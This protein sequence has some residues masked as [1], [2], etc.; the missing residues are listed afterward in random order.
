MN[1][2]IIASSLLLAFGLSITPALGDLEANPASNGIQYAAAR[3]GP[4]SDQRVEGS[5]W[6][7]CQS[8]EGAVLPLGENVKVRLAPKTVAHVQ[9]SEDGYRIESLDG[10]AFVRID[11]P[12]S[13]SVD[14]STGG[15]VATQGEFVVDTT[16]ESAP[17]EVYSG[18]ARPVINEESSI[19]VAGPDVRERDEESDEARR[20]RL[21]GSQHQTPP[22]PVPP[23]VPPVPPAV[24]PAPVPPPV[25]PPNVST[26]PPPAQPTTVSQAGGFNPAWVVVPLAV[27]GGI[28]AL[29][30]GGGGDNPNPVASP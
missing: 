24:P 12:T 6:V 25:P 26:P 13:V 30:S 10:V 5:D 14:S 2:R 1:K 11:K 20:A 23:A 28:I 19:R 9:V 22:P 3:E 18:D 21:R 7:R 4:W 27:G 17:V 15:A 16:G 29:V 8:Q